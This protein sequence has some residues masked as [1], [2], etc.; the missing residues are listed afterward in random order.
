MC[1]F[2]DGNIPHVTKTLEKYLSFEKYF[3]FNNSALYAPSAVGTSQ[4]KYFWK[5]AME[6]VESFIKYVVETNRLPLSLNM[7]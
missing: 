3:T 7:S 1:T 2:S 6:S 4:T 5:M